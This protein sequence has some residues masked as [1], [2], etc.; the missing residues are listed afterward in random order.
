M[1]ELFTSVNDCVVCRRV[2]GDCIR[3][4]EMEGR[5]CKLWLSVEGDGVDGV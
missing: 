4:L 3:L 2:D 1:T 5:K